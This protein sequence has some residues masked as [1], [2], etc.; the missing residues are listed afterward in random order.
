MEGTQAVAYRPFQD[1]SQSLGCHLTFYLEEME[2]RLMPNPLHYLTLS[3][4]HKCLPPP[5]GLGLL[6]DYSFTFTFARWN[7]GKIRERFRYMFQNNWF[8]Q[9]Q[10]FFS[11]WSNLSPLIIFWCSQTV[12]LI[13]SLLEKSWRYL[14]IFHY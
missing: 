12:L 10:I 1:L 4:C 11:G 8:V 14:G 13:K 9:N 6:S 3:Y 7:L 5:W 2:L